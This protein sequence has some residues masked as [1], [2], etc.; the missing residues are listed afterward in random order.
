[1]DCISTN[2]SPSEW[3]VLL[4][5]NGLWTSWSG[6]PGYVAYLDDI[7][8]TGANVTEHLQN[9]DT[10][11]GRLGE[12]GLRSRVEKCKFFQQEVEYLG[13][14]INAN[15]L[16][17]SETRVRAIKA[18]PR[19]RNLRELLAF[20]G[21]VN[22]YGKFISNFAS[23]CAPLHA[24]RKKGA[25]FK[26]HSEQE[27]AFQCL[28]DVLVQ[29]TNLGAFPGRLSAYLSCGCVGIRHRSRINASVP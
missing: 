24:L 16:R 13:H 29:V 2:V 18:L 14:V 8:V 27:D 3:S 9:L 6:I 4:S 10:L 25:L 20:L 23:L 21:K 7:I 19:P 1:M 22:Y 28:K 26:W 15:G 11:L 17:L 12:N 5:F